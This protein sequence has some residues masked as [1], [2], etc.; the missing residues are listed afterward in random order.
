MV[1]EDRDSMDVDGRVHRQVSW[2]TVIMAAITRKMAVYLR[3]WGFPASLFSV[4]D[5]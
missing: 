1:W 3:A 5:V 4:L 2:R